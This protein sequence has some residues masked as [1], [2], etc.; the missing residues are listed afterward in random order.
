[1]KATKSIVGML[2]LTAAFGSRVHAQTFLTNGLVA[3][4]PFDGNAND[5]SGN[6]NNGT[7]YGATLTQ[8]V[9]G[10]ANSAYAFD[11]VSNYISI[12]DFSQADTST[13]TISVWI[14]ANSWTNMAA[15]QPYVDIIDKDDN[16]GSGTRQWVFQGTRAGQFR[17]ALFTSAGEYTL[18]SIAQ[19]QTNRWYQ[20]VQVWDGTN[21]S[22]FI[23]G[24]FDSSIP[25]PGTLV[26]AS[27]PV[28][29]GGN[30]VETEQQFFDGTIT[31]VR[32][33]DRALSTN[34]V[35]E[36]Y[37]YESTPQQPSFLTNGLLA[38]YPFNGNANDASGNGFNAT[39]EGNYQ[40]LTNGVLQLIGDGAL[41]YSGG[42]Y[43]ALPNYGNLN[44]GFTMS[45]W[46]NGRNRPRQWRSGRVLLMVRR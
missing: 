44:S 40:Y 36:L 24:C 19:L 39:L 42:G 14:N 22:I 15:P 41:F 32:I 20:L 16:A 4:Y 46:V 27:L 18:N 1:M 38:Y 11:G 45:L 21:E 2:L 37:A 7:V 13:H 3:Y 33:Y 30:P 12:P 23:N 17:S 34:E 29:I 31:D 5:A 26:E 9:F 8:N 25:A 28:R 6:G 10:A 35:A 43:V